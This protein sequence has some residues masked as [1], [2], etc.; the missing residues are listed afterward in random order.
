MRG[1]P[2]MRWREFLGALAVTLGCLGSAGAVEVTVTAGSGDGL[3]PVEV[4]LGA[5]VTDAPE[6]NDEVQVV[7]TSW[8]WSIDA[9][10]HSTDGTCGFADL[11][12]WGVTGS[13]LAPSAVLHG[14]PYGPGYYAVR[15]T[16][17]V[18]YTL[19][20]G[21]TVTGSGSATVPVF[22]PNGA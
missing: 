17:T 2:R 1:S 19:S 7:S 5:S 8:S 16:V 21:S 11:G 6:P 20:D 9:V 13:S 14:S 18:T 22:V 15:L 12:D 10:E 3:S 4:P